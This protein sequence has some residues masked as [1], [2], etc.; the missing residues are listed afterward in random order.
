MSLCCLRFS[1]LKSSL[2]FKNTSWCLFGQWSGANRLSSSSSTSISQTCK[3]PI[4]DSTISTSRQICWFHRKQ[5]RSY[6]ILS[7]GPPWDILTNRR[8]YRR[9]WYATTPRPGG[10]QSCWPFWR[11][12]WKLS[13]HANANIGRHRLRVDMATCLLTGIQIQSSSRKMNYTK[14]H[15][16]FFHPSLQKLIYLMKYGFPDKHTTD[17]SDALNI[18]EQISANWAICQQ[19]SISHRLKVHWLTII[20]YLMT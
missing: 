7:I 20:Y 8:E 5:S 11:I 9:R 19:K 1:N 16:P 3:G 4:F 2:W 18:I 17:A 15:R 12:A 14:L 10:A 13:R 6:G